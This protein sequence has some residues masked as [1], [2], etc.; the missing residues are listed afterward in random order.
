MKSGRRTE[1]GFWVG[2][3]KTDF[4]ELHWKLKQLKMLL[5]WYSHRRFLFCRIDLSACHWSTWAQS[6]SLF[7]ASC[8]ADAWGSVGV[9]VVDVKA[10]KRG[11]RSL[12]WLLLLP[13]SVGVGSCGISFLDSGRGCC[14]VRGQARL[15][16]R[17]TSVFCGRGMENRMLTLCHH[18]VVHT[19]RCLCGLR[20]GERL[21]EVGQLQVWVGDSRAVDC[22]LSFKISSPF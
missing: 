16:R 18:H 10:T 4:M 7:A 22:G 5:T 3:R 14:R 21:R 11:S 2:V 20:R 13:C 1:F 17:L 19:C 8:T 12:H 15:F 6:L 9:V